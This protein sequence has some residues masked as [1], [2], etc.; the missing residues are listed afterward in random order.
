MHDI[1]DYA[2]GIINLVALEGKIKKGD[3]CKYFLKVFL[4]Q[5]G[6]KL[7]LCAVPHGLPSKSFLH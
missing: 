7:A 1:L 5:H 4:E 2:T 6:F 3:L